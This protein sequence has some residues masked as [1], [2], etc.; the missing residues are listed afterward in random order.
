MALHLTSLLRC[1][2]YLLTI[3]TA[4]SQTIR[5]AWQLGRAEV[6]FGINPFNHVGALA[7]AL[8]EIETSTDPS[9]NL[10]GYTFE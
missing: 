3:N 5:L 9:S 2:L 8:E 4:S 10:Y 7:Y 6:V 1:L